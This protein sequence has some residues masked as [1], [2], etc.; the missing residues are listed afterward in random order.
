MPNPICAPQQVWLLG[1]AAADAEGP[2]L[3]GPEL[4]LADAAV[5]ATAAAAAR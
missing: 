3:A 4:S 5:R 1:G 2:Y